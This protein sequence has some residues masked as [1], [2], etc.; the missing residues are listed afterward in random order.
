LRTFFQPS[1]SYSSRRCIFFFFDE[2]VQRG[3]EGVCTELN[4]GVCVHV[5]VARPARLFAVAAIIIIVVVGVVIIVLQPD[6]AERPTVDLERED[7]QHHAQ[8][9]GLS[10][11]AMNRN[12]NFYTSTKKTDI[13]KNTSTRLSS[14]TGTSTHTRIH[15]WTHTERGEKKKERKTRKRKMACWEPTGGAAPGRMGERVVRG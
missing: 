1:S 13:T 2:H 9:T 8:G 10:T 15:T 6:A 11:R 4:V 14:G 12:R 5:L 7:V 3:L